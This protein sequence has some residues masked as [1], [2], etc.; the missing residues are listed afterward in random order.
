VSEPTLTQ[1]ELEQAEPSARAGGIGEAA[2]EYLA[3]VRGGDVGAL[4][5]VLGLIVLALVFTALKPGPFTGAFNF[6]NLINQGAGVI[7]IAM[8]L[9]FVLL[10]GEI[11]LSAGYTAGTA[12]AT[13]G[14]VVTRHNWP[15]W[16][17]I[18]VCLATGA[19]IGLLIGLLV[20]RLGIP[21]FVVTLA[22]FLGLQG[23]LLY[24]IGEG[25][26]I[27]I[28]DD[29]LLA[30][31]NK[32]LPVWL[33]W[34]LYAVGM[35]LYGLLSYRRLASRRAGGLHAE[36]PAVW[37]VK[38]IAVAA[39]LGL[40]TWYLSI[41]RSQNTAVTSIKGV[42]MVVP[43]LIVLM[44]LLTFLLTRTAWGRHVYAVGGNAEAAR[45][46]GINVASIKLSCFIMCSTLAGVAGILISSRD[47]SVSPTTGGQQTLLY[48]VGAAV[49]GGTSLFGG[50]GRIIDPVIGGLVVAV[51]A[52]GMGLL[53]LSAAV[54]YM[55]TGLVLLVAA[56]VDALSRKRAAA[57]GR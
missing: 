48:A 34:A 22:A 1:A 46:A 36:S 49:I 32:N 12:A 4:P 57:T 42:P 16:S 38:F 33:G 25:G 52:N 39:L 31:M 55:V 23:V 19:L 8:G 7:V 20:A 45:R 9:V 35:G 21:S 27:P 6:A 56:S 5:A 41:E 14:I 28:R 2:S 24:I 17:G 3:K 54:I 40:A 53:G 13:M 18:I 30:V 51:I 10:L 26:T 37:A 29:V 43:V 15:W 47:N 11:D 50:K 44:V